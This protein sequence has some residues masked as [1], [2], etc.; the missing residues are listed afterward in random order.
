[1]AT[2]NKNKTRGKKKKIE[3]VENISVPTSSF[4]PD[5]AIVPQEVKEQ[6]EEEAIE[7]IVSYRDCKNLFIKTYNPT[8][9]Q[10]SS[11]IG[12][13]MVYSNSMP[14]KEAYKKAL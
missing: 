6:N 12:R 7:S 5:F 2:S 11:F 13:L 3:T 1:M 8:K 14:L 10:L 9:A 4:E